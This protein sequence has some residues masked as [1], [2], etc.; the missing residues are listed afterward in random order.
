MLDA[1]SGG[2][3]VVQN[4]NMIVAIAGQQAQDGRFT[5]PPG[6]HLVLA[7]VRNIFGHD[8]EKALRFVE[9]PEPK[10]ENPL[11]PQQANP[12]C[13]LRFPEYTL[14]THDLLWQ[15]FTSEDPKLA[16][17]ANGYN[18]AR[19]ELL[20][21]VKTV[22]DFRGKLAARAEQ[23]PAE[24][25]FVEDIHW[26]FRQRQVVADAAALVGDP[27]ALMHQS[28]SVTTVQPS[29]QGDVELLYDL[30]EQVVGYYAFD[31]VA[32][33]GVAVDIFSL[34]Y[35]APDGRLQHSGGNR[36][37]MRYI[38][39][40][41]ANRFTSLKRR[42]GRYVFLTLRNQKSPVQIRN[43]HVVESTYPLDYIGSFTCSDPRLDRIW[44]ISTRTLKLCMEDTF[45][46]CPLYEQTHWVGDARNESLLAYPVFGATDLARRCIRIS[47][48]SLEHY[49]LAGC[50]T[51]SSW[52]VLIPAWSFLWG[53]S[54][55][56][57]Y[58]YTGDR[59]ALREFW[60]AV[61]RNLR[62]AEKY[63]NQQDLFSAPFWNFFDWTGI[64][65]NR[66]TVLHNTMFVVGAAD[67]A[68]AIGKT[69]GDSSQ[70]E[71]LRGL[72]ARAVRG[73]NRLWNETKQAYP[74]SVHDDGTISPSVCQ[75]T[76]FLA[77][78]FDILDPAHR[79]A[80]RRNLVNPPEGMVRVGSPF[81]ALY[82]FDAL[83]KLGEE[84]QVIREIYR[85]YLPMLEA[86]ATTVW[87]S[88]PSGTTGHGGFPTR[89]HCHAWSSAPNYFLPRIVLGVRPTAPASAEVQIS[90]RLSG[91]T[92]AKGTV[93]TVRGPL[94]VAWRLQ[95][96]RVEITC[97]APEGVKTTCVSNSSLAGKKLVFNGTP[98]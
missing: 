41:G 8:K 84:D 54:V 32:E 1:G 27:A 58:W 98:Q 63:M 87:E 69:L 79:E 52:D 39:R 10:L 91:L 47:A 50:Q 55:W 26:R 25:M 11:D 6:R 82:L 94:S 29:P 49:P 9:P 24:Q 89:S 64:D 15:Q 76:S 14:A 38:T 70:D 4:E 30:G 16:A 31:L 53:I 86:G 34:E 72:R 28:P 44:E 66:K 5:L 13:F 36:N 68:L 80:A 85:N 88:F 60:P 71:W 17:A 77:V 21:S 18:A 19:Q 3:V 12:W 65:G 92:W 40:A 20:K 42:S 78:L 46:D 57:Y 75:H 7:F 96:D 67:A 51:P 83:E 33:A 90:P 23:M 37:G 61:V 2:T 97:T 81:A 43:F 59:E 73:V 48:Q 95:D 22:E 74:D 45:T 62:G 35:I 56:D 93:A